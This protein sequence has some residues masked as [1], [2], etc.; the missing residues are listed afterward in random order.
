M[1]RSVGRVLFSLLAILVLF[2]SV[3]EARVRDL[4]RSTGANKIAIRVKPVMASGV[5]HQPDTKKKVANKP[6]VNRAPLS[7][8]LTTYDTADLHSTDLAFNMLWRST[9]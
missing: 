2:T 9:V 1:P 7:L 6:K 4:M 3:T 8:G 5:K